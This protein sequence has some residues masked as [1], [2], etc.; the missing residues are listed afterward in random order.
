VGY[1]KPF[2]NAAAKAGMRAFP[3]LIPQAPDEPGADTGRQV[4]EALREDSRPK[5]VLWA[6][7]D[8][9]LPPAI[10][11]AF[12][13]ALGVD[14]PTPIT[15]AGH[16]LQEDKGEEIGGIIADWLGRR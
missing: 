3:G 7:G 2:P 4:L 8:T 14:P 6:D 10:G 15:G 1:E 16:F 9:T 13:A 5:L 11:D 12:A